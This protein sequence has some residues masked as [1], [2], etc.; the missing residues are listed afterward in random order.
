MAVELANETGRI[1][2]AKAKQWLNMTA[3]V[4]NAETHPRCLT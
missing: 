1:G 4:A 3:R 2:V